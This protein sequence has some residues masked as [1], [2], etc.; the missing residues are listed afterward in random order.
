MQIAVRLSRNLRNQGR[1][2]VCAGVVA[3][4]L[5]S[6]LSAR[7]AD[8]PLVIDASLIAALQLRAQQASPREQVQ[9]YA[10]LVDKISLLAS[11]EVAEGDMEKAEATLHQLETCTSQ[12]ES[13]LQR[14]SKG[15]KK[16][17][18]LLHNTH[19]RLSDLVRSAS[20]DISR[21]CKALSAVSIMRRPL[22]SPLSS[23]TRLW[24]MRFAFLVLLGLTA[25]PAACLAQR[26]ST[27]LSEKEEEAVRDAADD[28]ARRVAVYQSIIEARIKRIQDILADKRAQGRREDIRESMSEITG[29]VDELEDNL[30]EYDSKHRDLRKPL[31]KLLDATL[32][33]ESVLK[34]PPADDRYELVRKLAVESVADIRKTLTSCSRRSRP[35]SKRTRLTSLPTRAASDKFT[36]ASRTLLCAGLVVVRVIAFSF[37]RVFGH[38]LAGLRLAVE[39][40]GRAVVYL[41]LRIDPDKA[42]TTARCLRHVCRRG[43]RRLGSRTCPVEQAP[44][45][46]LRSQER[47]AGRIGAVATGVGAVAETGADFCGMAGAAFVEAPP[48]VAAYHACTP[49]CPRQAPSLLAAVEYVPSLH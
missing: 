44:R 33:W 27:A 18:L 14:D 48:G 41:A 20:G 8:I 13:G 49:L 2:A 19:R 36:T 22:C 11:K 16:T 9:M 7:A 34:Q 6:S 42:R 31:P 26:N 47:L 4:F 45:P 29:L 40:I 35:I 43:A 21:W 30:D 5:S 23:S 38:I 10:D 37:S 32:R 15:L 39:R 12:I 3:V 17:E 46:E 24:R 25:L 1:T 28:P